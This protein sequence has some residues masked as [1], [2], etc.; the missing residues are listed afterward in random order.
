MGVS[1][2]FANAVYMQSVYMQQNCRFLAFLYVLSHNIYAYAVQD[3]V[4]SDN[5][6][7]FI[8]G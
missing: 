2:L 8:C 6:G 1:K 4:F 5:I 3:N 7:R